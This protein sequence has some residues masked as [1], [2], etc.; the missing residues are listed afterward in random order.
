MQSDV[1]ACIHASTKRKVV[2]TGG[3]KFGWHNSYHKKHKCI[4]IH[5]SMC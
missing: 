4:E 2:P 1:P 5:G 3:Y